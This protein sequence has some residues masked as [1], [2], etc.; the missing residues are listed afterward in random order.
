MSDQEGH[1]SGAPQ[2]PR[3]P[4]NRRREKPQLSCHLCR[5]R[6]LKCDRLHPCANCTKRGLDL[7]CTYPS[8]IPRPAASDQRH[9][10]TAAISVQDRL[11]Q[12]EREVV[13]MI[14]RNGPAAIQENMRSMGNVATST[15]TSSSLSATSPS[16]PES[17]ESPAVIDFGRL[18]LST[19]ETTYSDGSHWTSI[20]HGICELREQFRGKEPS[21]IAE[22]QAGVP[23]SQYPGPLLLYGCPPIT[24]KHELLAAI[25]SRATVDRMVSIYFNSADISPAVI[26][27][28]EF[29]KQYSKFWEDPSET[30]VMWLGFLFGMLCVATLCQHTGPNN[31]ATAQNQSTFPPETDA[32]R[33]AMFYK[34]KIVQSLVFGHYTTGGPFVIETLIHYVTV[35]HF[36]G[37][38]ANTGVW[39]ALGVLVNIAMKMGYHRDPSHFPHLSPYDA[40]MRRRLWMT[41]CLLDTGLSEQMGMP[42][43]IKLPHDDVL[44]PR[45]LVDSDFDGDTIQLPPSRPDTE[46]TSMLFI[47]VKARF[48]AALHVVRDLVTSPRPYPYSEVT[49]VDA[50]LNEARSNIPDCYKWHPMPLSI[51]DPAI[52]ISRRMYLE[53]LYHNAQIVLHLRY[54]L[55]SSNRDQ[56]LYSQKTIMGAILNLLRFHQMIDE[57]TQPSG[58]LYSIR[59]RFSSLVSHN[60]LLA[61]VAICFYLEQNRANIEIGE[62]EEIKRLCRKSRELWVRT[63]RSSSEAAKAAEALRVALEALEIPVAQPPPIPEQLNT[64]DSNNSFDPLAFFSYPD[65]SSGFDMPFSYFNLFDRA[66]SSPM[67]PVTSD[68]LTMSPLS[69]QVDEMIMSDSWVSMVEADSRL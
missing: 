23:E 31:N 19:S 66:I 14:Q 10:S 56:Y 33:A 40:E 28:G 20:L 29:L 69:G 67:M 37:S 53:I 36:S 43:A 52:L 21:P 5:R 65:C 25:P 24:K 38:D 63:S 32:R 39:L 34:E 6:K 49:R 15:D 11:R 60:F 13:T 58:Q 50:I 44:E 48:S 42:R 3:P 9:P 35:E 22:D 27:T 45:H 41:I 61:T 2:R 7:E 64:L 18:K 62:L 12:L 26:H 55:P 57:E 16:E 30:P 68:S 1:E 51:T 4:L 17:V 47:L 46:P 54:L 59:W 8:T